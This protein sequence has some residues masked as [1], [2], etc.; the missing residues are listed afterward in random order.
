[1]VADPLNLIEELPWPKADNASA[2]LREFICTLIYSGVEHSDSHTALCGLEN[3]LRQTI[4]HKC[5]NDPA[6]TTAI[7]FN[8][9]KG[10]SA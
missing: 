3:R 2:E 10:H 8:E 6:H 1:M 9:F 5:I 4:G 7:F